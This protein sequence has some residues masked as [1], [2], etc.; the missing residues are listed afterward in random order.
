MSLLRQDLLERRHELLWLQLC[1]ILL[2]LCKL[3]VFLS[4]HRL[5]LCLTLGILLVHLLDHGID[6]RLLTL[7]H[8]LDLLL[9]LL[10]NFRVKWLF[11]GLLDDSW[12]LAR[13]LVSQT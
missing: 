4:H 7:F 10:L 8:F 3:L 5:Q 12:Y 13:V 2:Q 6:G 1:S 9:H 11:Y